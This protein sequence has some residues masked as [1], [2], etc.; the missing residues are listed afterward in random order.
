LQDAVSADESMK[1][2]G[3]KVADKY[4]IQQEGQIGV[5]CSQ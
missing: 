5:R 1:Q 3:A 4:G 2:S